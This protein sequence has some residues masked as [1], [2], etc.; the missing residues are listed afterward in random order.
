MKNKFSLHAF[1]IYSSNAISHFVII[2]DDTHAFLFNSRCTYNEFGFIFLKQLGFLD[3]VLTR[4]ISK[5]HS[6]LQHYKTVRCS[7]N[8]LTTDCFL[9]FNRKLHLGV[10]F[11]ICI[12]LIQHLC[13]I[14]CITKESK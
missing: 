1:L 2:T 12:Y 5:S 4:C 11:E 6:A 8:P 14:I 9:F 3:L 7:F 13:A 10:P